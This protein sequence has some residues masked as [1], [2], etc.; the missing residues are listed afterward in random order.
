MVSDGVHNLTLDS[1]R[2][3]DPCVE[4]GFVV[5]PDELTSA[6][7]GRIANGDQYAEPKACY[8]DRRLTVRLHG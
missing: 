7:E 2:S 3:T 6:R 1:A 8:G 4:C 5:S